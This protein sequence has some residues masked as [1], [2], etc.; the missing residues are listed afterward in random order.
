MIG[1]LF[2]AGSVMTIR[3]IAHHAASKHLHEQTQQVLEFAD[4][5]ELWAGLGLLA[6][7]PVAALIQR[8]LSDRA[9]CPLCMTPPL[10]H[11][12]CQRNRHA[13]TFLGSYRLRVALS[14]LFRKHFTCPYC[15]EPTKCEVRRRGH[16]GY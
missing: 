10:V 3:G 5:W 16:G 1:V 4:D 2:V 15:G 7:T 13:R 12:T 11:K 14:V 6:L 9:R 8:V